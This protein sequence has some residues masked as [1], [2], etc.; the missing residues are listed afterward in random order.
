MFGIDK[1]LLKRVI[2]F[3]LRRG[4]TALGLLLIERGW[5]DATDWAQLSLALAPILA[6]LAWSLYEKSQAD[7]KVAAPAQG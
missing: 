7:R 4:L 5:V 1:L 6:D 2:V 3:A